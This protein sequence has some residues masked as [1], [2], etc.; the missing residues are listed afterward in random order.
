M[1]DEPLVPLTVRITVDMERELAA[2]GPE[3][4]KIHGGRATSTATVRV[5]LRRALDQLK[6][7]RAKVAA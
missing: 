2:A 1:E 3:V 5:L 7:E 4:A 6:A